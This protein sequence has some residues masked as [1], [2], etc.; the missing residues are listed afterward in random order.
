LAACG[1][2]NQKPAALNDG[3]FDFH[4]SIC[5]GLNRNQRFVSVS[6]GG[7]I[8]NSAVTVQWFSDLSTLHNSMDFSAVELAMSAIGHHQRFGGVRR[9]RQAD[10]AAGRQERGGQFG[11]GG[12]SVERDLFPA[13]WAT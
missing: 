2:S 13:G 7:D 10:V 8:Y 1:K 12:R 6:L 4:R 3:G 9:H 11:G 5:F